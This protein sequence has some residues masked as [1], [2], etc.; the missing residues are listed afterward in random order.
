MDDGKE[1]KR[2]TTNIWIPVSV[3]QRMEK[4]KLV[5]REPWYSV[6]E[7]ALTELEAHQ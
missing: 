7:R 6:V 1:Y 3:I 2:D 4:L 5:P